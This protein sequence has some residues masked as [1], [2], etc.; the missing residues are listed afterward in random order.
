MPAIHGFDI[1]SVLE[2]NKGRIDSVIE[3]KNYIHI[4]EFK[5]NDSDIALEQVLEKEY[6]QKYLLKDKVL[7]LVGVA[8]DKKQRNIIDWK[9]K[10]H[11]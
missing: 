1:N 3:T 4:I 5:L 11:A 10:S 2:T 7:T 8:V 6:Y 9:M